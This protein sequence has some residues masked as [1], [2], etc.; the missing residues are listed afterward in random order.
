LH[1]PQCGSKEHFKDGRRHLADGVAVQ[2]FLCRSCGNRFSEG[3]SRKNQYSINSGSYSNSI[4]Q[5]CAS[6]S[7]KNLIEETQS[8]AQREG[9]IADINGKAVEYAWWLKKQGYSEATI[10]G[11]SKLL[12]IM[13]KRGAVLF[14]PESIKDTIAKQPWSLGR[15]ANAVDSYSTFLKMIGGKWQAPR[16]EGI[17]KI[18]FIPTENELDQIISG[19][20]N[21]YSTFLQLLKE[22]A[23]R[24]G[25]AW[26]LRWTDLDPVTKTIRITP[27]KGSNPRI[28]R[29]SQKLFNMLEAYPKNYGQNIFSNP[30][31]SLDNYRD[32]FGDQRK[33]ITHKLKNP[34]IQQITFHTF[35]HWK[36]TM[37]YHKTKD[38][39]HVKH[40]L[41]HKRIENTLMYIQ[42]A[43]ELFKGEIEYVSRVAKSEGEAC[44]LMEAGFDFVCD[45]NGN[46][47]FRKKKY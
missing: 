34:R 10:E 5:V 9:T 43:E 26:Q 30:N 11:K 12:K 6:R 25:E 27:E 29:L 17:H 32:G 24:S 45:F 47:L 23:A 14:D 46:K 37:E 2:R 44:L 15:K 8:T 22:T 42:L 28:V 21:R 4:S 16:Y 19:C 41:G 40:V 36:A 1:C 35:R 38:I 39:L 3:P 33:R 31:Q 18:P 20:S 13:V 7:A